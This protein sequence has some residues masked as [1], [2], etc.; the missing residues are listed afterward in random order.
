MFEDDEWQRT[1]TTCIEFGG[2]NHREKTLTPIRLSALLE[3]PGNPALSWVLDTLAAAAEAGRLDTKKYIEQ[4]F[5]S[6]GDVREF[7]LTLR[8][9]VDNRWLN[10]RHF[11]AL[12]KLG[13][14]EVDLVSY[15]AVATFFDPVE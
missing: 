6:R 4:M 1:V 12:K 3:L 8:D 2:W 10:D 7:C 14:A 5:A 9:V 11:N 15:A 13:C